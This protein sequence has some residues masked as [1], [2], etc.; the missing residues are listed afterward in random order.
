MPPL[1]KGVDCAFP[2]PATGADIAIAIVDGQH[3]S[4][5]GRYLGYPGVPGKQLTKTEVLDY[6]KNKLCIQCFFEVGTGEWKQG[7]AR[8]IQHGTWARDALTALGAPN[9][10]VVFFAIDTDT[11]PSD[12][13][14]IFAYLE[15]AASVL[16]FDRT[17]VYG[18]ADVIDVCVYGGYAKQGVQCQAWSGNRVSEL[19]D[20][21]QHA[22]YVYIKG[23]AMDVQTSRTLA[24]TWG[25]K[26]KELTEDEIRAIA[27][28]EANKVIED[29][30]DDGAT[31]G[32]GIVGSST[33]LELLQQGIG[34]KPSTFADANGNPD[35]RPAEIAK[36]VTEDSNIHTHEPHDHPFTGTVGIGGGA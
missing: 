6:L 35:P 3:P 5:I 20:Y 2:A 34:M 15:G 4:Y 18:E 19:A 10:V 28:D 11:Y 30:L 26:E 32:S 36:Y 13:D 9:N 31:V 29:R 1:L 22:R 27:R 12:Y 7:F 23:V 8:G 25:A 17:G 24:G 14:E 16:G 33:F 21:Y